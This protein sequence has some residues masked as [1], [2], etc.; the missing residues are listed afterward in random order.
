MLLAVVA[1]VVF[2]ISELD[3]PKMKNFNVLILFSMVVLAIII[4]TIALGAIITRATHGLTPNRTAVLGANVLIFANLIL[5]AY[6]LYQ[7]YFKNGQPDKVERSII[8]FLPVYAGW[9]IFVIFVLPFV[10]GFK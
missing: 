4:N 2:S 6:N 3:K 7:S 10:F 8:K 5:I 1:I 9:I